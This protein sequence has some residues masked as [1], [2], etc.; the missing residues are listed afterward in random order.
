MKNMKE[1]MQG[2]S[3][4]KSSKKK[5]D[6]EKMKAKMEVIEE[7]RKMA[8]DLMSEGMAD[9]FKKVSV[10]APDKEGLL[11]GLDKAEDLVEKGPEEMLA[12]SDEEEMSES[13]DEEMSP[14]EIDAKIAELMEKKRQLRG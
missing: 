1:L 10:A 2:M 4:D 11:E 13:E 8:Q 6:P 12:E 3:E 14:E 7:L 9:G 5:M